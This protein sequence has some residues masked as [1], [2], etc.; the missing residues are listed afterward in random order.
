MHVAI[1][2]NIDMPVCLLVMFPFAA[3][4]PVKTFDKMGKLLL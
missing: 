2:K 3:S 1:N 4:L